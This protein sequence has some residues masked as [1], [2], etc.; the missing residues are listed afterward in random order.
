MMSWL[1]N[2]ARLAWLPV[3]WSNL[4]L[5]ASSKVVQTA[6][7]FPFVG[8]F[9]L[10]NDGTKSLFES[11]AKIAPDQWM[12]PHTKLF[13]IYFGLFLIG[14]GVLVYN[15]RCPLLIKRFE[16][17]EASAKFYM[18][19]ANIGQVYAMLLNVFEN[20]RINPTYREIEDR[21]EELSNDPEAWQKF[22]NSRREEIFQHFVRSYSMESSE[23][24]ASRAMCAA[25]LAL[26]FLGLVV[27]SMDTFLAVGR[28][29]LW[30]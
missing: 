24:P 20:P 5:I 3:H 15:L 25:L 6:A 13:V 23:N 7:L 8:Y 21:W 18:Q 22:L 29:V 10:I 19:M 11:T 12:S 17:E 27:P 4:R 14:L 9:A 28:Q 26:G 1:K 30:V 2:L 16:N